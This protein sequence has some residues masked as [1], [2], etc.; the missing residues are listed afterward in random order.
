MPYSFSYDAETHFP[1]SFPCF[2][3]GTNAAP[4]LSA[5]IGPK[6]NPLASRPTTTSIFFEEEFGI[7]CDVKRCTRC[8][9]SVSK[10]TGLRKIG[11]MSRNT[12][13]Y[14]WISLD[15]GNE[16]KNTYLLWKIRIFCQVALDILDIHFVVLWRSTEKCKSTTLR[17]RILSDVFLHLCLFKLF[18]TFSFMQGND[19][20]S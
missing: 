11:K 13:P 18:A 15:R 7:V 8:V 20:N 16:E 9:I 3:T 10:T 17:S 2:L 12:I 19:G 6:R 14:M 5:M 4:N 1:G